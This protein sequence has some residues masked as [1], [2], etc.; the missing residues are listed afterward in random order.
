M[1][2]LSDSIYDDYI[3]KIINSI[4]KIK[5]LNNLKNQILLFSKFKK[6]V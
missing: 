4:L 6:I 1:N 5:K 3:K 2:L